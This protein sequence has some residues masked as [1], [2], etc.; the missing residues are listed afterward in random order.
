MSNS[1]DAPGFDRRPLA[2]VTGASSG[3]GWE[4]ARQLAVERN[5]DVVVA[6]RR[7]ERL[8]NLA[9]EV[10]A[11]APAARCTTV[12]CD[13]TTE[14]GKEELLG[15]LARL[16]REVDLLVNNAGFGTLGHFSESDIK[17]QLEMVELNCRVPLWLT[18][19]LLPAMR[20]RRAGAIINVCS[21]GAFQP[22][23]YMTTYG[24]TKAFLCSFSL[25]LFAE[26]REEA[27]HV[28]AH[29]PG[30]TA[31]EFH[32]AAGLPAK[33][34]Y[35]RSMDCTLVVRGALDGLKRRSPLVI[36]GLRN[37]LLAR[38]ARLT[39]PSLSARL[40]E[41]LLRPYARM[42]REQRGAQLE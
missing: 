8:E 34:D 23:T 9:A 41:Y 20:A 7:R 10:A 22:L 19:Q 17:R 12:C 31:T 42:V 5:Y 15:A 13:L 27:V 2:V 36:N 39:P 35:L 11:T 18:S 24:A 21:T 28:M 37:N 4:Y 26:L 32:V 6:A 25:G 3:L 14:Q 30:P 16:G 29:C 33:I 40:V 38:V 1:S